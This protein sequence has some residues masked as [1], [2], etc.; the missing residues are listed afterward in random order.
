MAMVYE[1]M[2]G[3]VRLDQGFR[4]EFVRGRV[5][6][7]DDEQG[8]RQALRILLKEHHDV[9]LAA[10][11]ASAQGVIDVAPV[12]LVITDLCM[13]NQSGL[14]LVEWIKEHH[15]SIEVIILTGYGELATAMKAVEYGA[16][17]YLEKPFDNDKMLEYVHHG[18]ARRRLE[19]ERQRLETLA[20]EANRFE[21]LGRFVSGM[22]H[23]LGTPLSVIRGH[24]ELVMAD[25]TAPRAQDRLETLKSQVDHCSEI[26]RST[27]A[28]LRYETQ[29]FGALSLE[30]L[31]EASLD[32]ARPA[33]HQQNVTV[34]K[35]LALAMPKCRGDFMLARQAVLNLLTNACQAMEGQPEPRHIVLRTWADDEHVCMCIS[36]N[37][38]GIPESDRARVFDALFTTKGESGTGLGLAVVK[39]IM[40]RHEGHIE[41]GDAPEGGAMFVLKFP[42]LKE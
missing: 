19:L 25:P 4:E 32:V 5:L 3:R 38:P 27:M 29:E 1:E 8:P 12:D 30:E 6:V 37:G 23:D 36:D 39:Y 21:T 22:L 7:V 10:D 13:P 15:P 16:F 41:L 24:A 28:F 18:L 42:I 35:E 33:L 14:E 2:V 26:V 17:A 9:Q 11:V 34:A 31:A 40:R 20:L